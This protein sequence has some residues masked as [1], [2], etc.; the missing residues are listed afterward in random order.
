MN[1][2]P[3]NQVMMA[4]HGIL[5]KCEDSQ[6]GLE[7]LAVICY[8]TDVQEY[9]G[10]NVLSRFQNAHRSKSKMISLKYD[11]IPKTPSG[12]TNFEIAFLSV[13]KIMNAATKANDEVSILFFTDG[14][15]NSGNLNLGLTRF[16]AYLH[17]CRRKTTVHTIG[18]QIIIN[19]KNNIYILFLFLFRVWKFP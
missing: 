3:Y 13:E 4:I 10:K 18:I 5:Q 19:N 16:G 6:G 7:N 17:S 11:N 1:G 8:G 12:C 9:G 14:Q 2:K 15:N